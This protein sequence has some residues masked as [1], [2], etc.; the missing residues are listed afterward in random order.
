MEH[1]EHRELADDLE[2]EAE[3]LE[4]KAGE[5]GE[6]IEGVRQEWE[7]KKKDPSV[8]GAQQGNE[9]VV[10]PPR[11]DEVAPGDEAS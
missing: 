3:Q 9:Q 1:E 4:T 2:R 10:G 7:A 5:L 11:E 8:P 6:D